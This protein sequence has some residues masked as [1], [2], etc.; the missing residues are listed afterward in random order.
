MTNHEVIIE[1]D[2]RVE[3]H[4]AAKKLFDS[5]R[6]KFARFR[7]I[8]AILLLLLGITGL[9]VVGPGW[10]VLLLTAYASLMFFNLLSPAPFFVRICFKQNP[11][12]RE[13]EK[14]TF[15]ENGIHLQTPTV[16]AD[17]KWGFYD[18]VL[19]NEALYL[20]V[21]GKTYSVIPKRCF[22]SSGDLETFEA[23]LDAYVRP[24]AKA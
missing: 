10:S 11:R 6:S 4:V 17:L 22:A 23:L 12:L 19:E 15:G 21:F 16:D 13:R 5:K 8:I 20:L 14:I 3:E 2:N 1:L 24:V 18:D 7:R 9:V